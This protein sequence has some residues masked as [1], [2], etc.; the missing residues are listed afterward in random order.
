MDTCRL[1]AST[2][3]PEWFGAVPNDSQDDSGAITR[4]S[5][6][7]RDIRLSAGTYAVSSRIWL[8]GGQRLIGSGKDATV[9]KALADFDFNK[10]V[11]GA[12]NANL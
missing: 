3:F 12:G 9:L 1:E 11:R 4:A 2:A 5:A 10:D 8:R 6:F 7:G